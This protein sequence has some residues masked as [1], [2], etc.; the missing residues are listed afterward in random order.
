MTDGDSLSMLMT[1]SQSA[2]NGFEP[3]RVEH[4]VAVG[5]SVLNPGSEFIDPNMTQH[6]QQQDINLYSYYSQSIQQQGVTEG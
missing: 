3:D 1:V 6:P 2:S 4:D 5:M